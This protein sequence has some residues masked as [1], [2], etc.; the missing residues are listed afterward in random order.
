[1]PRLLRRFGESLR[2][3]PTTDLYFLNPLRAWRQYAP[4]GVL[5]PKVR[6]LAPN[7]YAVGATGVIVRYGREED[8]DR[9]RRSGARQIVYVVDDDFAAGA[10][11][12][13]LPQRYREKLAAFAEGPWPVVRD[14]ADVVIVPGTVLAHAYG[15]KARIVPPAWHLPPPPP[16]QPFTRSGAI[17]LAYFGTGSHLSDLA[18]F[19]PAI[20]EA[21]DAHPKARLTLFAGEQA[22]E[23]LRQHRQV[24]VRRQLSWWRYRRALPQ[25]RFHLALYPLADTPFNRARSSNKLSEH[26]LT[27]AASLMSP[28]PALR[29]AAGSAIP[30]LF[31]EGGVETWAERLRHDLSDPEALHD[32]AEAVRAHLLAAPPLESSIE[33]WRAILAEVS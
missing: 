3:L 22:P 28:N 19:A 23:A 33:A 16:R 18:E 12:R 15:P 13:R 27:G 29:E 5:P 26:A 10:A 8:I 11:D 17:E 24:T 21:L 31:V 4:K 2:Q 1:M 25:M 6:R 9:L 30:G 14:T 20:S 7:V 32:R